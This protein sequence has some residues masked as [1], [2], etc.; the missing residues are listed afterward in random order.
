M[1][2]STIQAALPLKVVC[3]ASSWEMPMRTRP[4]TAT[5][6]REQSGESAAE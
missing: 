3:E 6:Q 5:G 2:E 4:L 1:K